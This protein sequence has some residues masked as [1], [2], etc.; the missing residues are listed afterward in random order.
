MWQA[1]HSMP[2]KRLSAMQ[3]AADT[4][5][6]I[7]IDRLWPRHVQTARERLLWQHMIA[8]R[9]KVLCFLQQD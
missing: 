2:Q 1:W 7:D 4:D 9:F 8:P 6:D 3:T 5:I